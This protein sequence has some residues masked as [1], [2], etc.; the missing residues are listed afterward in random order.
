MGTP[1]QLPVT[2]TFGTVSGEP[3]GPWQQGRCTV[4]G[5][6]V[7]RCTATH[8][9]TLTAPIGVGARSLRREYL[10]E[11]SSNT[12]LVAPTATA[13]RTIEVERSGSWLG[14]AGKITVTDEERPA[15]T[16][17][18][19]ATLSF[20]ALDPADA[21]ALIGV[22]FDLEISTTAPPDRA[23]SPG[24]LPQW[25][26][27]NNWHHLVMVQYARTEGPGAIVDDCLDA[28][29]GCQTLAV[30]R[31]GASTLVNDVRGVV[32]SAG[33]AFTGSPAQTRPSGSRIDY[34]ERNNATPVSADAEIGEVA[35]DF[36][37]R[38]LVL[39]H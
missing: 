15:G 10:F 13:L 6:D 30:A 39:E 21:I 17:I 8:E 28:G 36:N 24:A 26:F 1:N 5:P 34:L 12:A 38:V 31:P 2:H 14:S 16:V 9:F 35:P 23:R 22:P 19:S 20:A 7:L 37:D 33:P 4:N 25:F 18:G 3:G 27:T 11:F 32:I 29:A